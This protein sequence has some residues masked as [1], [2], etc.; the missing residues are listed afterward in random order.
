MR[1]LAPILV[2][3]AVTSP[4][5][6]ALADGNTQLTLTVGVEA[7]SNAL[8]QQGVDQRQDQ[9][10]RFF[11]HLETG[12]MF[13]RG[14]QVV[15]STM[16]GGKVYRTHPDEDALLNQATVRTTLFP[17]ISEDMRWLFLYA[18][19]SAKDRT[20]RVDHQGYLRASTLGGAGLALGPVV[21]SAGAGA[22]VFVFK[23]D[24]DLSSVGPSLEASAS[25]EPLDDLR[26]SVA[27]VRVSKAF[28]SARWVRR[29]GTGIVRDL[30]E[31]RRDT[32]EVW[33]GS[34]TYEAL[35]V[36]TVASTYTK[37][38]SNSYG[39]AYRRM[40]GTL[41]L[42][43]PTPI[44]LV[45]SGQLRVQKTKYHDEQFID[46]T[47]AIDEDNRNSTVLALDWEVTES[48]GAELRYS[49]YLQEAGTSEADYQRQLLF[50][51]VSLAM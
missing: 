41:T 24:E 17:L 15:L 27:L 29:T 19:G 28:R 8:R 3:V 48:L 14:Q 25:L 37:Q 18:K 1:R 6:T 42:S 5:V 23:P 7:D 44:A 26:L 11:L 32:A 20:E 38:D 40:G 46:E 16:S 21:V 33:V 43:V 22:S 31:V 49:L 50:L 30:Q 10:S 12:E 2:F 47:L 34:L 45:I 39:Q 35:F 36:A 51:G 13:G 4:P 9:A